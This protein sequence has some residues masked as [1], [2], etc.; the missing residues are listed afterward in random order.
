MPRVRALSTLTAL[1]ALLLSACVVAPYAPY[2][3]GSQVYDDQGPV[4]EVPPPPPQVEV[5]PVLPYAGAIW[6]GGYWGWGAGRHHWV[7]GRWDRPRAG[8]YWAPHRWVPFHGRWH[9]RGG[10]RRG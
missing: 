4:A 3:Q 8:F 2:R 9:L 6:L 5:I 7:P 1:S 10:W